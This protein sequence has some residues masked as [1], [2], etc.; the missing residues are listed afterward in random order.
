MRTVKITHCKYQLK[1]DYYVSD[2]G[3]VYSE[4]S[5]K[6]L[7]YALDRD[8]Y[9]KV[10][11]GSVDG[12]RHRYSVHRLVLENFNPVDGMENLQVNHKD[13]N[14]RNNKL[15]NLEWVTCSENNKHKYSIGLAS[16]KGEKNN[17]SKLSEKEV[18]E[19]IDMLLSKKYT[20]KEIGDKYGVGADCVGAIKRKENWKYLT[21]NIDFD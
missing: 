13:G 10:R 16:Q 18:L 9:V 8:G 4:A 20:Q 6:T 12:K 19:I 7:S 2:N 1:F 21:Q 3:S 14:K 15:E 17:A 11:L 5:N